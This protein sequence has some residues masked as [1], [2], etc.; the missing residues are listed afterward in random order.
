MSV[1]TDDV[2][3]YVSLSSNSYIQTKTNTVITISLSLLP[4]SDDFIEVTQ[5]YSTDPDVLLVESVDMNKRKIKAKT[6]TPGRAKISVKTKSHGSTTTL[7]IMV[8]D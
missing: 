3:K 2:T 4:E 8:S 7:P 1:D 5:I 6:I